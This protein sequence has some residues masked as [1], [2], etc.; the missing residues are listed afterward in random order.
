VY[1]GDSNAARSSAGNPAEQVLAEELEAPGGP[2]DGYSTDS[3][4]SREMR[5]LGP[6][7]IIDLTLVSDSLVGAVINWAVSDEHSFS[8]HRFIE[9]ALS[10]DSPLPVSF[11]SPRRADWHMYKEV[12]TN[13]LPME[14]SESITNPQELDGTVSNSNSNSHRHATLP[15]KLHAPQ[16]NQGEGKNH[17][18]GPNNYQSSEPTADACLTEQRR[19]MRTLIG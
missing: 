14:P 7:T 16:G 19:E 8:D 10:L 9:T 6:A 5:A 11:A 1:K 12:L 15:S 18:G 13:I 3:S 4:L 17:P 2:D